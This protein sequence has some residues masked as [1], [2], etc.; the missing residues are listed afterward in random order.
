M[1]NLY[2]ETDSIEERKVIAMERRAT[3]AERKV[4]A[5]ERK[6]EA[7]EQIAQTLKSALDNN[8]FHKLVESIDHNLLQ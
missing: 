2:K 8:K 4:Q 7:L 3:A 6:A 1:I 5:S